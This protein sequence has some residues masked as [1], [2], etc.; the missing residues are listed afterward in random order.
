MGRNRELFFALVLFLLEAAH[1]GELRI[2]RDIAQNPQKYNL[3]FE[4][5][6]TT[7][8]I[9]PHGFSLAPGPNAG[10]TIRYLT[11]KP[12]QKWQ[13]FR[14]RATN[15]FYR[16][17][18]G[19][20]EL[21]LQGSI[22][23][24]TQSHDISSHRAA[25]EGR[26]LVLLLFPAMPSNIVQEVVLDYTGRQSLIAYPNPFVVG[27]GQLH[28]DYD[29]EADAQLTLEIYDSSGRLVRKLRQNELVSAKTHSKETTLW[30]GRSDSG[31]ALASGVYYIWLR[32][33]YLRGDLPS[34]ET[35]FRVVLIR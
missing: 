13:S 9:A 23:S 20:G 16:L 4:L 14:I 30:D 35:S 25:A 32:V 2:D 28:I 24:G 33:R 29:L 26:M 31:M 1:A 3:L 19:D 12:G 15:I 21:I 18:A 5:N 17:Q 8:S 7:L 27:K 22:A 10:L 11:V 6:N 34:Y